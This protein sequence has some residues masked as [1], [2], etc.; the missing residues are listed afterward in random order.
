VAACLQRP[1]CKHPVYA[2]YCHNNTYRH[3]P[4]ALDGLKCGRDHKGGLDLI[5]T[6]RCRAPTACRS[7]HCHQISNGS[8]RLSLLRRRCPRQSAGKC[9]VWGT[10]DALKPALLS[11]LSFALSP[12]AVQ[13]ESEPHR[14]TVW[15]VG[16]RS[17]IAWCQ[18]RTQRLS[19]R[20]ATGIPTETS[21]R[22]VWETYSSQSTPHHLKW[23]S[24]LH[25]TDM[26]SRMLRYICTF[27]MIARAHAGSEFGEQDNKGQQSGQNM[28]LTP[29]MSAKTIRG[30]MTV[31]CATIVMKVWVRDHQ[32]IAGAHV[33]TT[34]WSR[35]SQ[36]ARAF[37]ESCGD[38]FRD[39]CLRRGTTEAGVWD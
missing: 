13:A 39:G 22:K 31:L 24:E 37:E 10:L 3:A 34:P 35:N 18:K 36:V 6:T 15:T 16:I 14:L 33:D 25:T 20:S 2:L 23:L 21:L 32:T 9:C 8:L 30:L 7:A 5:D 1:C 26:R 27:A 29:R 38:S 28:P 17:E 12:R 19:K 4:V 11:R